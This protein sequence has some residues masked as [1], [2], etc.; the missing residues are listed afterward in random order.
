MLDVEHAGYILMLSSGRLAHLTIRDS[1]GRPAISAIQMSSDGQNKSGWLGGW[2]QTLGGGWRNT[3]AAVKARPSPTR[4]QME[5]VAVTN[6][7]TFKL[8]DVNWT[9]QSVFTGQIDASREISDGLVAANLVEENSKANIKVT[10][11]AILHGVGSELSPRG[12]RSG[13]NVLIL[14]AVEDALTTKFALLQMALVAG[15]VVQLK[16]T[17]PVNVYNATSS[18][19][20]S[21]KAKLLLPK[22]EHI[23]Y[24]V[25]SAAVVVASLA[26]IPSRSASPPPVPFQD[27]IY[28]QVE[29]G[30]EIVASAAETLSLHSKGETS[31]ILVFTSASGV[32]RISGNAPSSDPHKQHVT[33][34]SKIEQAICLGS[35]SDSILDLEEIAGFA[36]PTKELEQAALQISAEVLQSESEFVPKVST[37][38]EHQ[39][40][41]RR[42]A[43][44]NLILYMRKHCSNLSRLTKWRLMWDAER[45]AAA[46]QIWRVYDNLCKEQP[47]RER[48]LDLLV[49]MLHESNKRMMDK[50]KGDTD[51]TRHWLTWDIGRLEKFLPIIPR[52]IKEFW[53]ELGGH[54]PGLVETLLQAEDLI[55]ATL[56]TPYTFREENLKVYGLENEPVED[57]V[58]REGYEGFPEVWTAQPNAVNCMSQVVLFFTETSLRLASSI[59]KDDEKLNE[60]VRALVNKHHRLVEVSLKTHVER[61][62][63]LMADED[64]AERRRGEDLKHEFENKVRQKQLMTLADV[65]RSGDGMKI[66]EKFHDMHSLVALTLNEIQY[67]R[68]PDA[69]R[70]FDAQKK[71]ASSK[72]LQ[73]IYKTIGRYFEL[74]GQDFANTFY[75]AEIQDNQLAELLE[76]NY[77]KQRQLTEFLRSDPAY[78]KLSWINDATA[79]NDL[80]H[81]GKSLMDVAQK[82]ENNAWSKKMELSLAKLAI[83][84]CQKPSTNGSLSRRDSRKDSPHEQLAEELLTRNTAE[85][86]LSQ[87]Q[88]RLYNNIRPVLLATIDEKAARSF[89]IENYG[90]GTKNRTSL[91]LLLEQ[92]LEELMRHHVLAPDVLI[93]I[94]TLLAFVSSDDLEIEI[95]GRETF[96]ALKVLDA[97]NLCEEPSSAEYGRMLLDLIWK[98]L[99]IR[100]DWKAVNVT[101]G[102]SDQDTEDTLKETAL[103]QTLKIGAEECKFTSSYAPHGETNPID[104]HLVLFC[105]LHNSC[106][107]RSLRCRVLPR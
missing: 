16:R 35:Q 85:R 107:G 82:Q 57:G 89:L 46:R 105:R 33:A 100:D 56:E 78:A 91:E 94:L 15:N 80:L 32:V 7:G 18:E 6:E 25:T 3:H 83:I 5:V 87:V 60:V 69:I 102:K 62:R 21:S 47:K 73:A 1:Q 41:A 98:R 95:S 19:G 71:A 106:P 93:N 12:G 26:E 44:L 10:D 36:F 86:T 17:I 50:T 28:F 55:I 96:L 97:S 42:K 24:I 103:F 34:K 53:K 72:K 2:Y 37:S 61:Y 54:N 76:Q 99:F 22:P 20:S 40:N 58:L 11:F 8:W 43:L 14:V 92:G 51:P 64:E 81:A 38:M 101:E 39:I 74:Y 4:G 30:A 45:M 65:S 75:K 77:G 23:A 90:R 27:A 13:L 70:N 52:G 66:A 88:D 29:K 63:L 84:G 67:H 104:S 59:D 68:D 31:S 49:L 9:G 48:L 79:E